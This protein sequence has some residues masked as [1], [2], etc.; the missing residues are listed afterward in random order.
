M[1]SPQPD[2]VLTGQN[3]SRSTASLNPPR[4]ST[5][6]VRNV[7]VP[8][9]GN[10]PPFQLSP[11]QAPPV[12][13]THNY[14][15]SSLP[16]PDNFTYSCS[17][18]RTFYARCQKTLV[19]KCDVREFCQMRLLELMNRGWTQKKIAECLGVDVR[20]V[21]R[22]QAKGEASL[23]KVRR[24]A[25]LRRQE[26]LSKVLEARPCQTQR[27]LARNFQVSQSTISRD[28][29]SLGF[30][31]RRLR[32]DMKRQVTEQRIDAFFAKLRRIRKDRLVYVDESAFY[33]GMDSLSRFGWGLRGKRIE[34][35]K[36]EGRRV[37][38]SLCL[39]A[40]CGDDF[41]Y[42][43]CLK[44]GSFKRKSFEG[45]MKRVR[46]CYPTCV[47]VMDN[48]SIHK[49]EGKRLFL[50]PYSPEYNP[51][52]ILFSILKRKVKCSSVTSL[53]R[54]IISVLEDVSVTS[55]QKI[56]AH[57]RKRTFL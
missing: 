8:K 53:R 50:P 22:W 23:L 43:I 57:C 38:Y 46:R 49:R 48:C 54:A 2:M 9:F 25:G 40:Q 42:W 37:R 34:R 27:G 17:L 19:M 20:T 44:K 18:L 1:Q 21:R 11:A 41:R 4:H 13:Y 45:F 33:V 56:W 29:R 28:L 52:E 35:P 30:T 47:L 26:S 55:A 16:I 15:R 36:N 7:A 51:I 39:A 32:P 31:R 12:L 3:T 5:V 24:V 10:R 6:T 14:I